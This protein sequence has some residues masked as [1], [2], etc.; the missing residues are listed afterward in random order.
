VNHGSDP[1][2]DGSITNPYQTLDKA[3]EVAN[4]DTDIDLIYLRA[5]PEPDDK[6]GASGAE[7]EYATY[8]P[9]TSIT[10]RKNLSLKRYPSDDPNICM[11]LINFKEVS[12]TDGALILTGNNTIEGFIAGCAEGASTVKTSGNCTIRHCYIVQNGSK[13]V[14][15]NGGGVYVS[16]GTCT[17]QNSS[18]SQNLVY[19]LPES[20]QKITYEDP[21]ACYGGGIYV[22]TG[23]TCSLTDSCVVFN[24]AYCGGGIYIS[25]GATC[26]INNCCVAINEA[27]YG[28]AIANLGT[29]N[30]TCPSAW[31]SNYSSITDRNNLIDTLKN[32]IYDEM[33]GIA[34]DMRDI[35]TPVIGINKSYYS[36]GA[37][38]NS[39]TFTCRSV[40]ALND[41]AASIS[42]PRSSIESSS[43]GNSYGGGAIYNSGKCTLSASIIPLNECRGH[44]GA[45]M[46]V[47]SSTCTISGSTSITGNESD[48]HGGGIYNLGATCNITDTDISSNDSDNDGGGI[49][50]DF[51]DTDPVIYGSC[52]M[53]NVTIDSNYSVDSGGGISNGTVCKFTSNVKI[54]NNNAYYNGG[55]FYTFE[56]GTAANITFGS[57][58]LIQGNHANCKNGGSGTGGGIYDGT[59]TL[60][61]PPVSGIFG[62]GNYRGSGTG[63]VDNFAT[64]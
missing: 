33:D 4:N 51:A 26:N 9:T 32:I 1:N 60:A 14:Q 64:P 56:A 38:M 40:I 12:L 46:N 48:E 2:G 50:N 62:T 45:I 55:G 52:T 34:F 31:W 5:L 3:V 15:Y 27:M 59:K 19:A 10:L 47:P 11:C 42:A 61:N 58:L 41:G 39:G 16:N 13:T 44:G 22:N 35:T 54:T 23:A 63:T 28:G 7:P 36:G 18:I 21:N 6:I 30:V 53:K 25:S 17:I 8:Y 49:Y 37:I 57:A 43:E 24:R 20:R 29:C